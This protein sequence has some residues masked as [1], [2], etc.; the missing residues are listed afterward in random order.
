MPGKA[1]KGAAISRKNIATSI[2]AIVQTGMSM[3]RNLM[4]TAIT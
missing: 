3:W 1:E 4:E 2:T